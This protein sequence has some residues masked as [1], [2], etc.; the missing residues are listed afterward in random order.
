VWS[1]TNRGKTL[2]VIFYGK[3]PND[4]G[5]DP[6]DSG[7]EPWMFQDESEVR[8]PKGEEIEITS[9]NIFIATKDTSPGRNWSKFKPAAFSLGRVKA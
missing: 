4:F 2:H 8:I 6:T 5:Y 1:A 3:I 7:E 9:V